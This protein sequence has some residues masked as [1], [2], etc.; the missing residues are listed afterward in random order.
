MSTRVVLVV[1]K[2]GSS[3]NGSVCPIDFTALSSSLRPSLRIEFAE[4]PNAACNTLEDVELQQESALNSRSSLENALAARSSTSGNTGAPLQAV[5]IIPDSS[6]SSKPKH[7][8]GNCSC[9]ETCQQYEGADDNLGSAEHRNG[10]ASG[11]TT[12]TVALLRSSSKQ[13]FI[14]VWHAHA[15]QEPMLQMKCMQDGANMVTDTKLHVLQVS[16]WGHCMPAWVDLL[17]TGTMQIPCHVSHAMSAMSPTVLPCPHVSQQ[18]GQS[19]VD[20]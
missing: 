11:W 17:G 12:D 2:E 5:L 16:A 13:A 14:M 18:H 4:S 20:I 7:D 19:L 9:V 15:T 3:D 1:V 10:N 6:T 8:A